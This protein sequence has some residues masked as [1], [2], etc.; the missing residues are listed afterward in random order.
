MIF[1]FKSHL[2][3]GEICA[4]YLFCVPVRG[5]LHWMIFIRPTDGQIFISYLWTYI[6]IIRMNHFHLSYRWTHIHILSMDHFFVIPMDTHL[7]P[8]DGLFTFLLSIDL[9]VDPIDGSSSYPLLDIHSN[10]SNWSFSFILPMVTHSRC[11]YES[12]T[13]FQ[14]M[15]IN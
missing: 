10:P 1:A 3:G 4:F 12:L 15:D 5:D 11:A 13:F 8:T 9:Y 6:Y 7:Y 2:F 14:K